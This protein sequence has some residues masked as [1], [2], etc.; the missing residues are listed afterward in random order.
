[1]RQVRKEEETRVIQANQVRGEEE[2]ILPMK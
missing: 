2:T 1:M